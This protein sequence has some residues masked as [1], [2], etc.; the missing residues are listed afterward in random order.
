MS[1][2][3]GP[4]VPRPT[5][6]TPVVDPGTHGRTFRGHDQPSRWTRLITSRGWFRPL[7]RVDGGP[8]LKYSIVAGSW[9]EV[10]IALHIIQPDDPAWDQWLHDVP[11]DIYHTPAYHGFSANSGEGHPYLVV[12]GDRARGVAW[13]Y[14]LRRVSEVPELAGA[15]ATDVHSV[16]GYPG[17]LAWGCRPGDS[18]LDSAWAQIVQ[19]WRDQHA[20]AAFTRFHPLLDNAA[21]VSS[22]PLPAHD[23][24]G[25]PAISE[26]G[27]TVSVDC[28]L[29]DEEALA[30][31]ARPLRQHVAAGRRAGLSTA[32]DEQWARLPT[33][34]ELYRATMVRNGAQD[35]YLFDQRYFERLRDSLPGHVHLLTTCLGDTVGAAG[36][37]TE[38]DGIVQAH[39][40]GTNADLRSFSPFKTLLHDA[41]AW[42]RRR[43]DSVLH[44]GG[45]RGGRADS[46]LRFKG[47]FSPR[48]H[49][50]HVGRW[51]LDTGRYQELV[52]AHQAGHPD[53]GSL[54]HAYFPA[55]RAR[56]IDGSTGSLESSVP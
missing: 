13:P 52:R 8:A 28:T 29:S 9:I 15:D 27:P 47:E 37:F 17:P 25:G 24:Q 12:V 1:V 10:P 42:A 36:I 50:F 51:V 40:V 11:K 34:V 18:F 38:F 4:S 46:L 6:G 39:L 20:V 26:I 32:H 45:G 55:Y 7:P 31:Y 54:D 14:L 49:R 22:V 53:G 2:A 23:P 21:L 41:R 33:F 48:R 56:F 30:T 43:G 19:V 35:F 5:A 16:Y 3:T 44:L